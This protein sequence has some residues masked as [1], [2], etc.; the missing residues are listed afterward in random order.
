[1][2]ILVT[3]GSGF[4]GS[5][6]VRR[7]VRNGAV[8][9][10]VDAL[11][12]AG[13]N[14]SV[15]AVAG[16]PGYHFRHVDICDAQRVQ[17][18]FDEF[19]PR[20]V[21]HAAAESHVD[22]SVAGPA[23]CVRTNVVGTFTMLE[24]ARRHF[25]RLTGDARSSFRFLH[26]STDEVFG[27]LGAD[28]AFT[29]TSPYDP[30]SPYA[31]TKAGS[32]HL[33]K[34]WFATYGLPVIITNSAN[35]YG[36]YQFPEKLIPVMTLAALAGRPLPVYGAG[37]NIREWLHVEDHVDGILA[38]VERGI[39][40]STYLFG[41]SV[42]LRNIDLVHM[43]CSI[44]DEIAPSPAGPA[45]RLIQFVED[46]PGHDYRY[47]LD[48]SASRAELGWLPQRDFATGLRET[49][50]WYAENPDWVKAVTA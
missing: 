12:Y 41:G 38:A 44:V 46:R 17:D 10:N 21:I 33:V 16:M 23:D 14:E 35:N 18:I 49:I 48:S 28:G 43:I 5:A 47:A 45:K 40:G 31:A 4:V 6:L 2:N 29:R 30:R 36:T 32:D 13:H 50:A 19:H 22:R 24:C 20:I 25:G 11:T 3:G 42:E 37:A 15:E 34:A 26:V 8:V 1:L 27:S 9:I 7:L 39:P